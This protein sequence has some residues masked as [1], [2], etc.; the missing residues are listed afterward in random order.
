[1]LDIQ[2]AQF[3]AP[4]VRAARMAAI[5]GTNIMN[6]FNGYGNRDGDSTNLSNYNLDVAE[7]L[8]DDTPRGNRGG[9]K[10]TKKH[11]PT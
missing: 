8:G 10:K 3:V 11:S 7:N 2:A 1:M 6:A 4:D 9:T 5:Q